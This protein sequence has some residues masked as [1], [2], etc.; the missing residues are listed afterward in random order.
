VSVRNLFLLCLTVL[1]LAQPLHAQ[2]EARIK[3]VS[4]G[5]DRL[6]ED[7][8][9]LVELSPTK[10]LKD[11][12]NKTL[13]ELIESFADGLDATRPIRVDLVFSK[14]DVGY[15]MHFPLGK[16][17][18]KGG[19]LDNLKGFGIN[20]KKLAQ[21]LFELTQGT[22]KNLKT[23]GFLREANKH[24]SIA[25]TQAAVP[26]N[27]PH[28]ITPALQA[29]LE[30]GYDVALELKND[31]KDKAGMAAR[32]ANFKELRKQLEAGITFKRDEDK[33]T[34]ELRKLAVVQNLNEAE[35]FLV[36]TELLTAN[37]VTNVEGKKG[38]GELAFT[39]LPETG[40][41]S[42]AELLA[43]KPSY[44]ANVKPPAKPAATGRLTFP[45]DELRVGH[46]KDFYKVV[47]PVFVKRLEGH[48]SFKEADQKA[49]AKQA[50]DLIIDM[51][52]AGLAHAVVDGILDLTEA[53]GGKH[54]LIFGIRAA[55]G[56]VAD[57]IVSL[58]PKIWPGFEIK[59]DVAE[60]GGASLHTLTLPKKRLPRFQKFF[61]EETLIHVATSK[62]AVW[63][64]IGTNAKADLTA[65]I[66]AAAD[67]APAMVD[68]VVGSLSANMTKLVQLIEALEPDKAET[69]GPKTTAQKDREKIRN[70]AEQA[71]KGCEPWLSME[72]K[73][74][75][76][77]ID[78]TIDVTECALK[79]VGTLI[80]DFA[81]NM[82]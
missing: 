35:R 53:D 13:K 37:W 76:N 72:L 29:Y 24:A 75:D 42:S 46:L 12:W 5:V 19:F 81:K 30:K 7:L 67:P 82:E 73:R 17:E 55:D 56:K 28:S 61:P 38:R 69:T 57:Q 34:F 60:I 36:E 10:T 31:P 70:L 45:V 20:N 66:N 63:I 58:F 54:T 51:L 26:A 77:V 8:K 44:F 47:R 62:D 64:A 23:S 4:P 1:L 68:P 3:V 59:L 49:A 39:A 2:S 21:G 79:V 16:L 32:L 74:N 6:K 33:S 25:P 11:Q 50:G 41:R 65:A 9:Y 14:A 15:E 40:L 48:A 52:E 78:G 18:G 71:V 22:K 27:M 80:A 43:A